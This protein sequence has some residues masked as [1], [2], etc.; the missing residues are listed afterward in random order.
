MWEPLRLPFS[1]TD[2]SSAA[3]SV[4]TMREVS[5]VLHTWHWY[6][7]RIFI[8]ASLLQQET[9]WQTLEAFLN[10]K[11]TTSFNILHCGKVLLQ[12][13]DQIMILRL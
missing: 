6:R 13:C 2:W 7:Y 10:L 12:Q 1:D 4:I 11:Y 8:W 9:K 3:Y 5:Q